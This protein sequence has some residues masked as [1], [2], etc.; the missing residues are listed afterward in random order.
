MR[1]HISAAGV[2]GSLEA[3]TLSRSR[4][5]YGIKLYVLVDTAGQ[6]LHV[7]LPPGQTGDVP[8]AE[9][10]AGLHLRHVLADRSYD[11]NDLWRAIVEQGGESVIPGRRNRPVPIDYDQE[12]YQ[13]RN[14]VERGI[15]WFKH[16]LLLATCFEKTASSYLGS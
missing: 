6:L 9:L 5:G 2:P 12:L 3:Q 13:E 4:G 16:C 7:R 8:Q 1:S 15:N 11:A 14:I 10:L